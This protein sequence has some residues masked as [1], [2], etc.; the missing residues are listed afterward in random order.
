M[1]TSNL[2]SDNL[3]SNN[4]DICL[5]YYDDSSP[6][7]KVLVAL[8]EKNINFRQLKID[9]MKAEQHERW[10]L[11]KVNPRGEVPVLKHGDKIVVES[12][13]IMK[14]IDDN[15]GTGSGQLYPKMWKFQP[16]PTIL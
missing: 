8:F 10:Y 12:S 4:T 2:I 7:R 11:E 6:S 9:L 1:A 15:L 14:Y 3:T 5:Y 13:I 16:K